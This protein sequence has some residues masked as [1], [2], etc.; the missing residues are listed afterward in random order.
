MILPF[1]ACQWSF[2][3]T[4]FCIGRFGDAALQYIATLSY[5]LNADQW[6]LTFATSANSVGGNRICTRLC[7]IARFKLSAKPIAC[8]SK[9]TFTF[10]KFT[11]DPNVDCSLQWFVRN[12]AVT[13]TPDFSCLTFPSADSA[14]R[15]PMIWC[16]ARV[17]CSSSAVR[18]PPRSV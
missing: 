15:N 4:C 17:S 8:T 10:D 11:T 7:A 18:S 2:S 5:D 1:S 13:L 6:Y 3:T 9:N 12:H 14:S 16:V